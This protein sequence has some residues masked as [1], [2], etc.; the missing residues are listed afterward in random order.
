MSW[1]E[2][3]SEAKV[4]DNDFGLSFNRVSPVSQ[5]EFEFE[6]ELELDLEFELEFELEYELELMLEIFEL[7]LILFESELSEDRFRVVGL[8]MFS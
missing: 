3:K 5:L 7:M 4:D 6:F 1:L 2:F 8:R